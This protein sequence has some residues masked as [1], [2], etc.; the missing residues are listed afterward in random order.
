MKHVSIKDGK[1]V[2]VFNCAQPDAFDERGNVIA[3][4]VSTIEVEDNDPR[5]AEYEDRI[6]QALML[7]QQTQGG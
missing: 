4:G 3:A 1:V 7:S 6:K 2:G 5:I